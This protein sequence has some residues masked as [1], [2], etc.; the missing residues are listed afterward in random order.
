MA[1]QLGSR[2][3]CLEGL[4]SLLVVTLLLCAAQ[5]AAQTG[6]SLPAPRPPAPS[7]AADTALRSCA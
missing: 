4:A 7:P 1:W 2:S 5:S 3:L 6:G